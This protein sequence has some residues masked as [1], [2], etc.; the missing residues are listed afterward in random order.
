MLLPHVIRLERDLSSGDDVVKDAG[1]MICS[2]EL[3]VAGSDRVDLLIVVDNYH[4]AEREFAY[5]LPL[6]RSH[7]AHVLNGVRRS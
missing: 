2:I 6:V 1:R 4:P 5:G 3:V 7:N